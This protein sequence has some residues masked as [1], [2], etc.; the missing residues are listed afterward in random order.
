MSFSSTVRIGTAHDVPAVLQLT[1][2]LPD[3]ATLSTIPGTSYLLVL[4]APEGAGLAAVAHVSLSAPKAQLDLLAIAPG[5]V[6]EHLELR[7]ISVAEAL[8]VAFGCEELDVAVAR[9]AA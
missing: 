9:H 6:R 4:D 8:C 7:M 5:F 1:H 3:P 2:E